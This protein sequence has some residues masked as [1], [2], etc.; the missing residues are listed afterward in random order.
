M[1]IL[2]VEDHIKINYLLA[3]FARS[4]NH[5]VTQAYNV[6]DA[7]TFLNQDAFDLIITDL[8]LP[9]MQGEDFIKEIRKVSDIYIL[10]ISSKSDMEDKLDVLRLGVDDYITKPFSVKE[11]MIK[12]NQIEKRMTSKASLVVSVFHGKIKIF[13]LSREI[14]VDDKNITLTKNEYDLFWFLVQHKHQVFSR[15]QLLNHLFSES[16][17]YDRVI[18]VYIKNIRKKFSVQDELIKTHYGLGYQFVGDVDE[19]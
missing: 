10:V 19:L 17:A 15:D 2:I 11:V 18:D 5:Q 13:P 14:Y 3:S 12:L 6:E 16:D 9:K 1:K 4:E 8:M 7:L